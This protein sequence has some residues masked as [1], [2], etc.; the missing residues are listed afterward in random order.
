M[1]KAKA[2]TDAR[3]KRAD[4]KRDIVRAAEEVKEAVRELRVLRL[5]LRLQV[6]AEIRQPPKLVNVHQPLPS[7]RHQVL[8]EIQG[9]WQLKITR[10]PTPSKRHRVL[11]KI[12]GRQPLKPTNRPSYMSQSWAHVLQKILKRP[13]LKPLEHPESSSSHEITTEQNQTRKGQ[14]LCT[15]TF[16][17]CKI[18]EHSYTLI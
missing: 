18:W 17:S 12:G 4:A 15:H 11:V 14:A 3:R 6:L 5:Y 1:A 16:L 8:R 2:Y 10:P 7:P 9:K 13:T